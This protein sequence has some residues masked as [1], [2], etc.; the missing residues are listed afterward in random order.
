MKKILLPLSLTFTL[1]FAASPAFAIDV[2]VNNQKLVLEQESVIEN[3]R[4]LVPMRPIFEALGSQV[5]YN[6]E[7]RTIVSFNKPEDKIIL[8]AIDWPKI[9]IAPYEASVYR[10]IRGEITSGDLGAEMTQLAQP[11]DVAPKIINGRTMVPVRVISETLNAKVIWDPV[12]QSVHINSEIPAPVDTTTS[13]TT[14]NIT[15]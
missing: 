7:T 10:V 13:A 1:L 11:I 6:D 12:T 14:A 4:T 3:G 9:A 15:N 8:L 2:I 5:K